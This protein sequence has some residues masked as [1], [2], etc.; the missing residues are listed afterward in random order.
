MVPPG[1]GSPRHS[2]LS[3]RSQIVSLNEVVALR[4]GL[5]L[6]GTFLHQ[7]LLTNKSREVCS[8]SERQRR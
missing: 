8:Y 3:E 6:L 7:V 1:Q 5:M 4:F 2:Q